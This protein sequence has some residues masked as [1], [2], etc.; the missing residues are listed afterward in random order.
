MKNERKLKLEVNKVSVSK[1]NN[2][3]GAGDPVASIDYLCVITINGISCDGPC[4]T[5]LTIVNPSIRGC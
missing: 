5:T 2:I 1:L 3:K 4:Q